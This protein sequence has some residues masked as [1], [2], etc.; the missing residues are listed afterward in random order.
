MENMQVKLRDMTDQSRRASVYLISR[1][2]KEETE[3]G[4]GKLL[5]E[6]FL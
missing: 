4:V 5:K 2:W 6:Q 3:D 1:F